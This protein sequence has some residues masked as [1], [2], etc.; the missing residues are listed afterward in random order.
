MKPIIT[1]VVVSLLAQAVPAQVVP[2]MLNYQAVLTDH[3]GTPR[4]SVTNTVRFRIYDQAEGGNLVWGEAHTVVTSPKGLFSVILGAGSSLGEHMSAANLREAFASGTLVEQRYLELQ[5]ISSDGTPQSPILPRQRFL[6]VPYVFQAND[7]QEAAADFTVSGA[8]YANSVGMRVNKLIMTNSLSTISVAGGLKVDGYGKTSV[9]ASFGSNSTVKSTA[10]DAVVVSSGLT[11][12]GSFTVSGTGTFARGVTAA[13]PT[14]RKGV[15][16]RGGVRALK[17]YTCV[18]SNV[19]SVA[20]RTAAGDGFALFYFRSDGFD[21]CD[22]VVNVG[23]N[24]FAFQHALDSGAAANQDFHFYETGCIPIGK[25]LVWSA[26][27]ENASYGSSKFDL[28]WIP[29][30][31]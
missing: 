21:T 7:A 9:T 19:T 31:Y 25:G 23:T 4:A 10:S 3:L 17:G 18:A 11:A 29:F 30:G 12:N 14:F 26:S 2:D 15:Y 6:T 16:V 28:Y 22:L 1:A 5:S 13:N 8:L 24:Q 20:P 27:L